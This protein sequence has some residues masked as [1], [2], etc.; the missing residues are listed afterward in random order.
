MSG[1]STLALTLNPSINMLIVIV[2]FLAMG[3][4]FL[5]PNLNASLSFFGNNNEKGF[6]LGLSQ[7]ASTLGQ[8][9]GPLVIGVCYNLFTINVSWIIIAGSFFLAGLLTIKHMINPNKA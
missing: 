2:V 5:F 8:T 4:G 1:I 3:L 6:I 7:S 9:I